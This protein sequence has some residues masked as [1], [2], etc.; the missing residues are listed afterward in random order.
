MVSD[1]VCLQVFRPSPLMRNVIWPNQSMTKTTRF[2]SV[3][4]AIRTDIDCDGWIE[5]FEQQDNHVSK[6]R[7]NDSKWYVYFAPLP[8][9]DANKTIFDLCAEI[10][11]L[12]HPI[13]QHWDNANNREF[14]VGYH[15][16]DEPQCY[17]QHFEL[18]TIQRAVSL[19]ASIRIAL[20][21]APD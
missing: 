10:E 6:L 4:I 19:N 18:E 16:G 8:S 15:V 20:Y 3:E 14:Y 12:P 13:R 11:K 9:I 2:V 1:S 5:W 7:D 17:D 21:P